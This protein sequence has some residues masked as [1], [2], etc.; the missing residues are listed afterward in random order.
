MCFIEIT[1]L[2]LDKILLN[3]GYKELKN[4]NFDNLN[5]MRVRKI[6]LEK[7]NDDHIKFINN[8]VN[9]RAYNYNIEQISFLETKIKAGKIIPAI[10]T[11]TSIIS[12]LLLKEIVKYI[13]GIRDISSYKNSYINSSI[14]LLMGSDPIKCE[15]NCLGNSVWNYLEVDYDIKISDLKDKVINL[16]NLNLDMIYY[17]NKLLLSPM[18]SKDEIIRKDNLKLSEL[19]LEFKEE[20]VKDRVYELELECYD[21]E[22]NLPNLK[23]I[24]KF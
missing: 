3:Y 16:Y 8:C 19:M 12:G 24:I 20:V 13:I 22:I 10:S 14:N 7:D 1:E 23:F 21:S 11:T 17:N 2:N 5:N 18:N 6:I 4:N 15:R 9:L